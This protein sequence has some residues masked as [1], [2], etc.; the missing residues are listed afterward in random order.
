MVFEIQHLFN[1]QSDDLDIE[2]GMS[3][4][5]TFCNQQSDLLDVERGNWRSYHAQ[6]P[7]DPIVD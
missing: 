3:D 1:Q 4:V 2:R 6:Y 7:K 5:K